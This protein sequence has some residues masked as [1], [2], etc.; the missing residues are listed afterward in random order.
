MAGLLTYP[1]L[2]LPAEVA[3]AMISGNIRGLTAAG[4]VPVSHRIPF[5]IARPEKVCNHHDRCKDKENINRQ[6]F[7]DVFLCPGPAG[8][9][10]FLTRSFCSFN[11]RMLQNEENAVARIHIAD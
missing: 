2:S 8:N 10:P 9:Q 1:F 7:Y 6:N 3:V 5:S 4:T 11:S